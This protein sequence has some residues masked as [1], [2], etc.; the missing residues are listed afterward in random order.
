MSAILLPFLEPGVIDWLG[1]ETHVSRTVA[2]GL[3]PAVNMD[4]GYVNLLDNQQRQEVL[5]RTS[6]LTP[7]EMPIR[8]VAGAFVGDQPGAPF[9]LDDYRVQ[10]EWIQEAGGV[11]VIFQSFGLTGQSDESIIQS[12]EALAA[13]C[14]RIIGFELSTVFAPFGAIYSEQVYRQW[15]NIPQFIGAKHSSLNRQLEWDRLQ[16]RDEQRSDFMVLT[17]NDL[18]ID[19]VMYG[20]DYLLGLSTFAPDYFSLRDRFWR[21][22]D[23]RFYQLNDVLQYLGCFAFRGPVPGYK[24]NAAQFLKL[25]QWVQTDLTHSNSTERPQSDIEVL[26]QI[27]NQLTEFDDCKKR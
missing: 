13:E 16:W 19:M 1:F 3:I 23:P 8:F 24:H 7:T 6:Q 17:G 14:E 22:N 5:N 10:L 21:D 12:Y 26:R 2:A 4:T 18:A 25:R 20:S 27:L 11:P 15:L 9:A